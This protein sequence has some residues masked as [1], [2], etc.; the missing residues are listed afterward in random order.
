VNWATFLAVGRGALYA[1]ASAIDEL[2]PVSDLV[3]GAALVPGVAAP[4]VATDAQI[5][6]MAPESV[7]VD[8]AI[9]QGRWLRNQPSDDTS[10]AHIR[11]VRITHYCVTNMPAAVARTATQ[12]LTNATLPYVL[13]LA[14]QGPERA[15]QRYHALAA[16]LNV[17]GGRIINTQVAEALGSA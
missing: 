2:L 4:H 11:G 14:N 3:I 17:R 7:R 6:R 12:A 1:S 5:A 16:G 9:D 8:I 13:A 10:G 15:M